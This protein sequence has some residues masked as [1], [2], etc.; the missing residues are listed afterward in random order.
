MA[1]KKDTIH[2]PHKNPSNI[3]QAAL[4]KL[5]ALLSYVESI[6]SYDKLLAYKHPTTLEIFQ[7]QCLAVHVARL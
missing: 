2:N 5:Y 1:L 7:R 4:K 6:F 3:S